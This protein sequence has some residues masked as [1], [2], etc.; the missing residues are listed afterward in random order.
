MALIWSADYG[1]LQ[2]L[3]VGHSHSRGSDAADPM[4]FVKKLRWCDTLACVSSNIHAIPRGEAPIYRN[5]LNFIDQMRKPDDD[6]DDD[7]DDDE[8]G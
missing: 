4:T 7:N 6:D 2:Q 5:S 8:S 3:N 1:K